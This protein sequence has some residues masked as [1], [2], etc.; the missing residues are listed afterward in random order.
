MKQ[1]SFLIEN[2]VAEMQKVSYNLIYSEKILAPNYDLHCTEC[3]NN[4][5][6]KYVL[7]KSSTGHQSMKQAHETA[8]NYTDG[9]D[10]HKIGLTWK[11]HG[12]QISF[13]V[14]S[15]LDTCK[16]SGNSVTHCTIS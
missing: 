5:Y 3:Q 8:R 12:E 16:Q 6:A 9:I 10:N 13:N 4:I 15:A 1:K 14:S 7:K 11:E 2:H